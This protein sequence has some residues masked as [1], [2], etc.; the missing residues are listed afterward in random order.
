M[1]YWQRGRLETMYGWKL[2]GS[3]EKALFEM[4]SL[5]FLFVNVSISHKLSQIER[6]LRD[7]GQDNSP[8][9]SNR[10]REQW[11]SSFCLQVSV[12]LLPAKLGFCPSADPMSH[13]PGDP[14]V[15]GPG[16]YATLCSEVPEVLPKSI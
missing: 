6:D 9:V 4:Q 14:E 8:H 2:T 1:F 11:A 13:A 10:L 5:L 3:Q 12:F 7:R 15:P 16:A